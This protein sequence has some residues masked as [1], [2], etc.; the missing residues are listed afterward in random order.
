MSMLDASILTR[1]RE[2]APLVHN[3][4]N[5]VVM[6]FTANVLLACGA[7]PVMSHAAEEVEEM[8]ALAGA[9]VLNIGTLSAPWIASMKIAQRAAGKRGIPVVLDP[10]GA[11]ATKL[12]TNTAREILEAG[13]VT[14]VRGN[15]SEILALAGSSG[16]TKGVDSTVGSLTAADAAQTLAD[17]FG[18]TVVVSGEVDLVVSTNQTCRVAN[19]SPLM[20]RVTGMGCSASALCG[21]FAAAAPDR[22]P[23][24]ALAAMAVMGVCGDLAAKQSQGTG[25]FRT[26][27]L[28]ALSTL[29]ETDLLQHAKVFP[30]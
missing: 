30:A 27:F 9:L 4:T 23:E 17:R 20:S 2:T 10:V 14:L 21:A 13:S 1:I 3:I 12:R 5:Y 22:I 28:D 16:T 26:A 7:S 25:T 29:S 18:C 8:A 24:A 19:G 6:D 15:G 11:G